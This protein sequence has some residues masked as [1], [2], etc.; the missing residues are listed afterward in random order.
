MAARSVPVQGVIGWMMKWHTSRD[1]SRCSPP[2]CVHTLLAPRHACVNFPAGRPCRWELLQADGDVPLASAADAAAGGGG[3]SETAGA[4]AAGAT[5]KSP[6]ASRGCARHAP[7]PTVRLTVMPSL[8]RGT[9][10][11]AEL[12]WR[13]GRGGWLRRGLAGIHR[14]LAVA[15]SLG[16]LVMVAARP[17]PA[18]C[19][20]SVPSALAAAL[21]HRP[22]HFPSPFPPDLTCANAHTDAPAPARG[23]RA[24]LVTGWMTVSG[25]CSNSEDSLQC[26]SHFGLGGRRAAPRARVRARARTHRHRR[27]RALTRKQMMGYCTC[28]CAVRVCAGMCPVA[29]SVPHGTLLYSE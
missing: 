5:R 1:P 18:L 29:A 14:S 21:L 4:N 7:T 17:T 11:R 27:A 28:L 12:V 6:S 26:I 10:R 13:G 20:P 25:V 16:T 24:Q 19:L 15:L 23:G 2:C 22:S 8:P 3:D 9:G